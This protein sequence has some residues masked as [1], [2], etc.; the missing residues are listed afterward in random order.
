[1]YKKQRNEGTAIIDLEGRDVKN[2]WF[3]VSFDTERCLWHLESVEQNL[4]PPTENPLLKRL[5]SLL[6]DGHPLWQGTASELIERLELT[7]I[8]PNVL[9]RRL[10][11]SV[12]ELKN[13]YGISLKCKRT[14]TDRLIIL[15][16]TK[17]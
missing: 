9:T 17:D 7:D 13:R 5:F 11:V 8:T 10:N 16:K 1:M 3:N 6:S 14:H 2:Q 15:E 4:K 12:D